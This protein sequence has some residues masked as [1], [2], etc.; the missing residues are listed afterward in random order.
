MSGRE[1]INQMRDGGAVPQAQGPRIGIMDLLLTVVALAAIGSVGYFGLMFWLDQ[2]GPQLQASVALAAQSDVAWTDEDSARCLAKARSAAN[3]PL[4]AEMMVA[5][6][7]VTEGFSGLATRLECH[8]TSKVTRLCDPL[9][10][11]A[12]VELVNDYLAR[13]DLVELGLGLQGAPMALLGGM[14]GGE[15]AAGSGIYDEEKQE[16]L[17]FMATYHRRI[18]GAL[19]A[20]ARDGILEAK[21]FATFI[22]GPP[23]TVMRLFGKAEPVRNVCS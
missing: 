18:G 17:D 8:L 5:N 10:K 2:K 9:Q 13:V 7:A 1:L 6:R 19:Q 4:P 12:M 23:E 3:A 11:A 21:D 14:M 22:S 15:V 16:T 20:L